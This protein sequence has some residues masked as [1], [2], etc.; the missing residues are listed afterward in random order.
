MNQAYPKDD[1]RT[2][3]NSNSRGLRRNGYLALLVALVLIST[4]AAQVSW[5]QA[6]SAR[7]EQLI[8]ILATTG[9]EHAIGT[10][11]SVVVTFEERPNQ[12]GLQVIFH[13]TPGRFSR[14]AQTAIQDAVVYAARSLDQRSL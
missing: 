9:G 11:V 6:E 1:D 5:G 7:R 12:S 3:H 13:T 4:L 2:L 10:V 8:P 14:L